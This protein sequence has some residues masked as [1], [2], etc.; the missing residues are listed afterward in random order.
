MAQAH[1]EF[2]KEDFF[3]LSSPR[4]PCHNFCT[5]CVYWF[6]CAP[7][8]VA[9]A[10]F[11]GR[12]HW[13]N[14][15]VAADQQQ[16]GRSELSSLC[17]TGPNSPLLVVLASRSASRFKAAWREGRMPQQCQ[18]RNLAVCRERIQNSL[19]WKENMKAMAAP[20]EKLGMSSGRRGRLQLHFQRLFMWLFPVVF[21]C[22][23]H[24]QLAGIGTSV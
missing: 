5:K 12:T 16:F 22:I 6:L 20:T 11:P 13:H 9:G 21:S 18:M 7:Q 24:L 1:A 4:T 23:M 14:G 15:D 10:A 8:N 19:G 3:F 2:P 17:L